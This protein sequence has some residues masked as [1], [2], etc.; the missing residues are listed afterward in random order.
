MYAFCP[1]SPSGVVPRRHFKINVMWSIHRSKYKQIIRLLVQ[2]R[3]EQGVTQNQLARNMHLR[4]GIISKIETCE[5]R[6]DLLELI[7]YCRG[8]NISFIDFVAEVS[9]KILKEHGK[10]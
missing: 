2:R 1:F 7:N 8:V 4:Q 9:K 3:K 6:M 10:D 5:R